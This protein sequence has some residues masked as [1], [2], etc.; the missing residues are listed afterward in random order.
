MRLRSLVLLLLASSGF[1]QENGAPEPRKVRLTCS[2]A[3]RP[4]GEVTAR[5]TLAGG[6]VR[7][8]G[9][10]R[11]IDYPSLVAHGEQLELFLQVQPGEPSRSLGKMALP[12]KG[13]DFAV[14]LG[15]RKDLPVKVW[16]LPASL[17]EFPKGGTYLINRGGRKL[18]ATLQETS[19][20]IAPEGFALLGFTASRRT[21]AALRIEAQ[22]GKSWD[23]IVS[24]RLIMSPDQRMVLVVGPS[25]ADDSPHQ[26]RGVI[27]ANSG[28]YQQPLPVKAAPPLPDPPAK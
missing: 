5:T 10:E 19:T 27:D 13:D 23:V 1:A 4:T 17:A 18:K 16:L 14:I 3:D 11:A 15:T 24:N 8:N 6:V 9:L 21:V 22:S 12:T 7:L 28:S 26:L 25:E 20:E 2:W